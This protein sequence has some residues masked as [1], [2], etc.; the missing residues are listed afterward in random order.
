M[1]N[2]TLHMA[3]FTLLVVGGVNWGLVGA[4][5]LNLVD[6]V[7][8]TMPM[9]EQLVYIAVGVSAVYEFLIHMKT[10]KMCMDKK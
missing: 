8:G 10:C 5:D 9:V 7:L 3:T 2:K 4:F 6:S 1:M